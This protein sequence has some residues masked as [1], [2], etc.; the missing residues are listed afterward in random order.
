MRDVP[1]CMLRAFSL[2][3]V[4]LFA[5]V[6][7]AT[8]YPGFNTNWVTLQVGQ[9]ETL[10]VRALWSG[11]TDYGFSPW[12]FASDAPNVALVEG[13]LETTREIANVKIT[14]LAEGHARIRLL[15]PAGLEFGPFVEIV[16]RAEAPA[17][18]I[19]VSSPVTTPGHPVVLTA[20]YPGPAT[21]QWFAG[22]IGDKSQPITDFSE[23]SRDLIYTPSH[24]GLH[25]L[26]VS[27]W[28]P[29]HLGSAEAVIEVVPARRRTVRH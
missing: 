3:L 27:V 25:R 10:T 28:T 24:T 16:V 6:A 8:W 7:E 1:E 4:L 14:A 26:W 5:S 29:F 19:Q 23:A 20:L 17:P 12:T 2:T 13:R 11:L 15:T 22:P 9:S 18:R 21:F